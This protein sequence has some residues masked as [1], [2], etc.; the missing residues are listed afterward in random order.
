M[1]LGSANNFEKV[2]KE[3]QAPVRRLF[4]NLTLGDEMLSDDLAQDTFIKAYTSWS[5]FRHLS[6]TRTWLFR[7]AYNVFYD[8]K[9]SLHPTDDI[10][11]AVTAHPQYEIDTNLKSDLYKAMKLLSDIEKICVTLAL[12]EDQPIKTV[13]KITGMNENTVKSHIRRGKEKMANF[14]KANNYG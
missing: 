9:R 7:I 6:S 8:Y 10:E 11:T 1:F 5:T 4:L 14:L 2:V 3:Y 13:A 12:V